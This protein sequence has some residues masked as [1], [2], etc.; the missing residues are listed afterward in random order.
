MR[1]SDDIIEI[2]EKRIAEDRQRLEDLYKRFDKLIN[3][4]STPNDM[5]IEMS[6]NITKLADSLSKQTFQLIEMA[7]IKQRSELFKM[8]KSEDSDGLTASEYEMLYDSL[9]GKDN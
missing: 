8:K 1:S 7:K 9:E 6:E 4:E 3:D 5:I 2:A